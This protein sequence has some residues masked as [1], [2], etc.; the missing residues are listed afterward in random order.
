MDVFSI[1]TEARTA[2]VNGV[3]V[4]SLSMGAKSRI[5][6]MVS[7]E[8]KRSPRDCTEVRWVALRH[9]LLDP[10]TMEPAL[11]DKDRDRFSELEAWFVEPIFE[12]ILELS[13]VTEKDKEAFEGN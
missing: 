12:K 6:A 11:T 9:A 4:R 3:I 1:G 7:K 8:G 2:E 13:G 5:E 10:E